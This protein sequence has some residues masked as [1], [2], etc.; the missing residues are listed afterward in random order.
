MAK[1]TLKKIAETLG[2]SV[3]TVSKALKDYDDV[4][5][6]TKAKV[7]SLA[8]SL[9]YKPNFLA[10]SLRNQE[11]K[12]IGLIIPEIV[13][14]F[15]AS[16]IAGVINAAKK[17]GYLVITLQSGESYDFEK[18]QIELLLDKNVDGILLSLADNTVDY[19]HLSNLIESGF[20]I[21]LYD[22]ITKS[23]HCSKVV[24]N[25][26]KA[27]FNA[28]QYLIDTGCK[29]IAHVRGPLKPQTTIDRFIGYKNALKE[30]DIEFDTSIVFEAPHLSLEDGQK[31]AKEIY[32]NHKDVD[33]V[34]AFTDL[35]ATGVMVGLKELNVK[36]PEEVSIMGFSNWLLTR[37]TSP[38]LSTVNQ[39]GF[40]MGKQAFKVLYKEIK[41][42]KAKTK[43]EFK[44]VELPTK[45][46]IRDSTR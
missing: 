46:V 32:K 1:I 45:L 18:K 30:N 40:K 16:I 20:P 12:T 38:K 3:A 5:P 43:V 17:K 34:F 7:K 44:T 25:D 6:E 2:I 23:I 4:S 11:S 14:H 36:I 27:A 37:I 35:T 31:I 41:D 33:A 22:K 24:I 39:P 9:N 29:K 19:M 8:E 13:H 28:T 10:Q 21:V 15:F 42:R 26:Q